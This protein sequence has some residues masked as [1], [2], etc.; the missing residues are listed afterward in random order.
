MSMAELVVVAVLEL[1]GAGAIRTLNG[2]GSRPTEVGRPSSHRGQ[3]AGGG[4][5]PR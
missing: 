5:S 4:R 2:H 1:S 3:L